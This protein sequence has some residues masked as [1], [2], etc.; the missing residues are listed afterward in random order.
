MLRLFSLDP[1]GVGTEHVE[2]FDSYLGRLGAAHCCSVGLLFEHLT[3]GPLKLSTH[4]GPALVRPNVGNERMLALLMEH[5]NRPELRST[6]FQSLPLTLHRALGVFSSH[7]RWCIHCLKEQERL[8]G[9]SYVKLVWHVNAITHCAVHRAPLINTCHSCGKSSQ[10]ARFCNQRVA[11]WECRQPLS[12][13]PAPKKLRPSW[14]HPDGD[15]LELVWAIGSD[16]GIQFAEDGID[17]VLTALEHYSKQSSALAAVSAEL[18]AKDNQLY[19]RKAGMRIPLRI[20]RLIAFKLGISL[21]DALQGHVNWTDLLQP[22][23]PL[24]KEGLAGNKRRHQDRKEIVR[25][26]RAELA[27]PYETEPPSFNQVARKIG[28]SQGCLRHYAPALCR[29]VVDRRRRWLIR[30]ATTRKRRAERAAAEYVESALA[31]GHTCSP[32]SCTRAVCRA[33]GIGRAQARAIARRLTSARSAA[34][35]MLES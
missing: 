22:G 23:W 26:M 8:L 12:V 34:K 31:E 27:T 21:V 25:R 9:G 13:G 33:S 18:R 28:V 2:G 32:A 3:G 5:A 11:C 10:E 17:K 35:P 29:R 16:P 4:R 7:L 20:I 1:F 30:Q 15:L 14:I 19:K 6:T 24:P